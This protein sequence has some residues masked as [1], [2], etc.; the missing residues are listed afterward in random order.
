MLA[1]EQRAHGVVDVALRH[2][3]WRRRQPRPAMRS[4]AARR[5]CAR[6]GPSTAPRQDP[7]QTGG[8]RR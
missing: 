3:R 2:R 5:A 1:E 7:R 6:C 8:C 4:R